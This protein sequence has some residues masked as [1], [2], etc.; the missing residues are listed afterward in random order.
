MDWTGQRSVCAWRV[1]AGRCKGCQPEEAWTMEASVLIVDDDVQLGELLGDRLTSEGFRVALAHDGTEG[2]AALREQEPDVV[3]LDARM[4]RMDGWETCREMRQISKVP[5]I[6]LS[7]VTEE[8]DKVRGLELGADDYI[9]KPFSSIELVARIRAVLRRSQARAPRP[10]ES[11]YVDGELTVD[12]VRREAHSCR[13]PVALTR[14]E[15]QILSCL[16]GHE[17]EV[18]PREQLLIKIWGNRS[19]A[20]G[21]SLRQHMHHL[22]HK[23]ELDPQHPKRIVTRR[24]EGYQLRRVS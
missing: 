13:G 9:G 18:V 15:M 2:L 1:S 5:I 21:D 23:I 16:I 20:S 14:T 19:N 17:G 10:E 3:V 12:L 11:L 4:P 6:F 24:G 7:C 8:K 22:R